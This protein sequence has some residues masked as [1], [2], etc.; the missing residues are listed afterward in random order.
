MR[1]SAAGYPGDVTDEEWRTLFE[2]RLPA[3]RNTCR[4]ELLNAILFGDNRLPVA[5]PAE[6]FPAQ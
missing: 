3:E 4:R 1:V 2:P 6:G 5:P